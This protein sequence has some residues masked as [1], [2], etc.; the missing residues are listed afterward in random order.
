MDEEVQKNAKSNIT[1]KPLPPLKEPD[2][3]GE[4]IHEGDYIFIGAL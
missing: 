4:N 3:E 1:T 2:I